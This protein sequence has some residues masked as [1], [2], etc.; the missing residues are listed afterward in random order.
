MACNQKQSEPVILEC[1]IKDFDSWTRYIDEV[2]LLRQFL[3]LSSKLGDRLD[4][5]MQSHDLKK[6]R[7]WW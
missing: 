1:A 2:L 3:Y 6:V 5:K 7:T 4:S